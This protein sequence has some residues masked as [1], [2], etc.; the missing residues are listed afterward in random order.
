MSVN[1]LTLYIA[2]P[3]GWP[4]V[5]VLKMKTVAIHTST[6]VYKGKAML[7]LG[8]SGTGKSTHTRLICEHHKEAQLLND[9]SPIVRI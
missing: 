4:T 5:S 1:I 8:E 9:D 7:A 6:I 2:W 3:T